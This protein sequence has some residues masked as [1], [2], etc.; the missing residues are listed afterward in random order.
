MVIE[1]NLLKQQGELDIHMNT[2]APVENGREK[3]V[4]K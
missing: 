1:F 3:L 2:T 4:V